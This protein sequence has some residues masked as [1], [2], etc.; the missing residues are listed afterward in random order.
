MRPLHQPPI[1]ACNSM[2]HNPVV[3]GSS[4]GSTMLVQRVVDKIVAS[5]LCEKTDGLS[6]TATGNW[7]F[8]C[9]MELEFP[10]NPSRKNS[11]GRTI[12]MDSISAVAQNG[13]FDQPSRFDKISIRFIMPTGEILS[14][15]GPV[16]EQQK[17]LG[18]GKPEDNERTNFANGIQNDKYHQPH[19][20]RGPGTI[21]VTYNQPINGVVA[22]E[23]N[24]ASCQIARKLTASPSSNQNIMT[25]F[26]FDVT[27]PKVMG[28]LPYSMSYDLIFSKIEHKPLTIVS[29][30]AAFN[31]LIPQ[32][33]R[34]M[35]GPDAI[36][37]L[38][39]DVY[40][41]AEEGSDL[42]ENE[43][44]AGAIEAAIDGTTEPSTIEIYYTPDLSSGSFQHNQL[45]LIFEEDSW[46]GLRMLPTHR[47]V[48]IT[49]GRGEAHFDSQTRI[50][51]F[52]NMEIYINARD[53][54][55]RM[56]LVLRRNSRPM[57]KYIGAITLH[58]TDLCQKSHGRSPIKAPKILMPSGIPAAR[59][60]APTTQP[61]ARDANSHMTMGQLT[62]L[63]ETARVLESSLIVAENS[64]AKCLSEVN[65]LRELKTPTRETEQPAK[66]GDRVLDGHIEDILRKMEKDVMEEDA[67]LPG[68]VAVTTS[69]GHDG[70]IANEIERKG[71]S[72]DG[73]N[74]DSP[75]DGLAQTA[76]SSSQSEA[77][78]D[79][80]TRILING[81]SW[82]EDD[83][84]TGEEEM[85]IL[86]QMNPADD[87]MISCHLVTSLLTKS[88]S[89][90][91][92][93][94]VHNGYACYD[95]GA[96][97]P[98]LTLEPLDAWTNAVVELVQDQ[99]GL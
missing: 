47:E 34:Q 43:Y 44:K 84:L 94:L 78:L 83:D 93:S 32:C 30:K 17:E 6:S 68:I 76:R 79:D 87:P 40:N 48:L 38:S 65:M 67:P 45:V 36:P 12:S 21:L 27:D 23:A 62:Q 9:A 15:F 55:L 97:N 80:G 50:I 31:S 51:P 64:L 99:C 69:D 8:G 16:S 61:S 53:K 18:P 72:T 35:N 60:G 66:L 81:G 3:D 92:R 41:W 29:Y 77:L 58:C 74:T 63:A 54:P 13:P 20:G 73:L 42:R 88:M 25:I 28:T 98:C 2:A 91:Y 90:K 95:D 82:S 96:I 37:E 39:S 1:E 59:R 5:W 19:I 14:D 56:R 71:S 33:L 24:F 49:R 11:W 52:D 75:G 26:F 22:A 89:R 85:R 46:S 86:S 70:T 7:R 4:S 57:Q 10:N